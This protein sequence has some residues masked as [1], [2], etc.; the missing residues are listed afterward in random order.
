LVDCIR[1]ASAL[2][3]CFRRHNVVRDMRT[4]YTRLRRPNLSDKGVGFVRNVMMSVFP[5]HKQP[6]ETSS[7]CL[8]NIPRIEGVKPSLH[9]EFAS[10]IFRFGT[11]VACA[12]CENWI[13]IS[14]GGDIIFTPGK[15]EKVQYREDGHFNAQ[16]HA[17][18]A[19]LDVGRG[20]RLARFDGTGRRK[21][22]YEELLMIS[23]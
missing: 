11:R 18:N 5:A 8:D 14:W 7:A 2:K 13:R 17:G 20:Q 10:L 4:R 22:R 3:L 9:P 6:P 21:E 23:V 15:G 16:S 1:S 19:N 12:G